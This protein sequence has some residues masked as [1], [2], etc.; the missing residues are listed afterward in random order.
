MQ[1][2]PTYAQ[3]LKEIKNPPSLKKYETN[4][5]I[6][7]DSQ[8][9]FNQLVTK[10]LENESFLGILYVFKKNYFINITLF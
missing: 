10:I 8:E 7:I 5:Y 1:N 6:Y 2:V 9:I 4:H 3:Q